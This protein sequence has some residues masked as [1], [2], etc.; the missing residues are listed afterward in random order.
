VC[1]SSTWLNVKNNVLLVYDD[2]VFQIV[3]Y[4]I[5]N[6]SCIMLTQSWCEHTQPVNMSYWPNLLQA[7]KRVPVLSMCISDSQHDL[8]G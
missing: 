2:S 7:S 5:S 3:F 1:V 6:M 8:L 4:P